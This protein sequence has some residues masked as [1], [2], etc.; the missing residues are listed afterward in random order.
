MMACFA[1]NNHLQDFFLSYL[2]IGGLLVNP[3]CGEPVMGAVGDSL[4][5]WVTLYFNYPFFRIKKGRVTWNKL[6]MSPMCQ[7]IH[8]HCPMVG[9]INLVSLKQPL[10]S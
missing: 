5:A 2:L 8:G 9:F 6:K 1:G 3:L 4:K 7:G 10:T